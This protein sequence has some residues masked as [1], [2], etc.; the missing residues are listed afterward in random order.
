MGGSRKIQTFKSEGQKPTVNHF[1]WTIYLAPFKLLHFLVV[2]RQCRENASWPAVQSTPATF[3]SSHH[4]LL[5]YIPASLYDIPIMAD[6][7]EIALER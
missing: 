7:E 3:P 4:H 5:T 1:D 2:W 6:L